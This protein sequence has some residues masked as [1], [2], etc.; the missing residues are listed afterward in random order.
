MKAYKYV[1]Y[2]CFDNKTWTRLNQYVFW[3]N[4]PPREFFQKFQSRNMTKEDE[5]KLFALF[6]KFQNLPWIW[7]LSFDPENLNV[8]PTTKL[9]KMFIWV[10]HDRS[11]PGY[12]A[13][14]LKR[15][16]LVGRYRER[17]PGLSKWI[18]SKVQEPYFIAEKLHGHFL[19]L[20]SKNVDRGIDVIKF[21]STI[22][23]TPPP[24]VIAS[25]LI[26]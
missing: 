10:L 23:F 4:Q 13:L 24:D 26:Q 14:T 25:K 2:P 20:L 3:K 15:Q 18:V 16:G 8:H 22:I 6:S 9:S 19:V 5:P 1:K 17:P 11:L 7:K 21:S 12:C